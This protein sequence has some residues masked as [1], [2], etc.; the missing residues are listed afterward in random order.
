ML[1]EVGVQLETQAERIILYQILDY[2]YN[3]LKLVILTTKNGEEELGKVVS[4]PN[5]P[6]W[7][8]P[9]PARSI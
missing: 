5:L 1:D 7:M 2:R 9:I 8:L 6:T 3:Y 4:G